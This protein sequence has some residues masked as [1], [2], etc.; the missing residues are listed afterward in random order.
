M[1]Y[2]RLLE[3]FWEFAGHIESLHTLYL[4][5]IAGFS[6]LHDRLLS[7]QRNMKKLL[8][9]HKYATEEFQDTCS[10]IYKHLCEKD[11]S[12]VS[13]SPVMKQ[14]DIKDRTKNNGINYFL[15]GSHCVVSAYSYWE[16]Y[17]RIE[18]GKAIGVLDQNAKN[19]DET[20]GILNKYVVNDFWG[21]MRHLRNSI[22][23]KN[24]IANSH[25]SKCKIF[26]WFKPGDAIEL[27]YEKMRGIFLAMGAYR[28]E[29][30]SMSSPPSRGIKIPARKTAN[31]HLNR[32]TSR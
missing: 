30:H 11:F 1:N 23:H 21:D 13:M 28:N 20:R 31:N 29:L 12:P 6:I 3:L 17:L 5:S 27:D 7:H 4:D 10:M 26:K 15:L 8:G 19:S 25:I 2:N 16:E 18:I 9:N 24:G 22:I 32:D 14:G